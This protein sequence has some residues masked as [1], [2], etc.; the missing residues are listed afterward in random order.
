MKMKQRTNYGLVTLL[1]P[2]ALWGGAC[3]TVENRN[4]PAA[5][6]GP[7]APASPMPDHSSQNGNSGMMASAPDAA[8]APY[9]LQFI[10]TMIAHHQG[11]VD[12]AQM[13]ESKAQHAELK[14][15]AASIIADQQREIAQMKQ[16]REQ[17]YA[18]KSSAMN[19][20]MPGMMDSMKGMNMDHMKSASGNAFDLMFIDMMIPHH[21]GAVVMA[22]DALQKA[23]HAD[24]KKLAQTIIAAQESEIKTMQLWKSQWVK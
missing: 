23:E 5:T 24:I 15:L 3:G 13:A 20:E 9:D 14:T 11:A 8:N 4:Q 18:G 7:T 10:D 17:W 1:L 21:E 12:M 19:M 16:W 6:A 22:R 2:A